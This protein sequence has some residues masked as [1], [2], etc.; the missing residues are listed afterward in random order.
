MANILV[1]GGAG[2]IGSALVRKLV[3]SHDHD[4][5]VIDNLTT[6]S[7]AKLPKPGPNFRFVRADVNDINAVTSGGVRHAPG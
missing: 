4:V 5:V 1:T 7:L 3:E 2:N 6:G